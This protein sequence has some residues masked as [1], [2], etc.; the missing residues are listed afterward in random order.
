MMARRFSGLA[1]AC[2]MAV[3]FLTACSSSTSKPAVCTDVANLK[4]SVQDLKN[5]N[6][7]ENGVSAVS[8]QLSKIEQQFNTLKTDAKGQYSTQIDDLSKALSGLSSSVNA[9]KGN[10]NSATLSAVAAAAGSVVSA[11]NNLVTAVSNTC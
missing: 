2:V 10:V 11:G 1:V 8:D 3:A 4:T 6:V 9:A 5:V 7:R